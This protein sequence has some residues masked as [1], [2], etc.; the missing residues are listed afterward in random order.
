MCD[1]TNPD[2]PARVTCAS[3]T[4]PTKPVMTTSDRQTTMPISDSI[5]ACRYPNGNTINSPAPTTARPAAGAASRRGRG[6]NGSRFSTS[7]PRD[8]RLAPRSDSANTSRM[9]VSSACVP[10]IGLPR[11]VGN[12][13]NVT[14]QAISD[15]PIPIPKPARQAIHS[16]LKPANSAAA[17]AGTM[18]NTSV[19][20]SA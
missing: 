15:S 2:T 1:T 16:D 8:G 13:D 12:H 10:G 6:A 11:S 19:V 3:D 5:K 4:W 17:S 9:N 14:T 18:K 7:S 20:E